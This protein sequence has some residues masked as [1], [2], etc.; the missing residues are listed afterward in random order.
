MGIWKFGKAFLLVLLLHEGRAVKAELLHLLQNAELGHAWGTTRKMPRGPHWD[1]MSSRPQPP[2]SN[3]SPQAPELGQQ[4]DLYFH[5]HPYSPQP[6]ILSF[7]D[8]LRPFS[9]TNILSFT[10]QY[11]RSVKILIN[12]HNLHFLFWVNSRHK[13]QHVFPRLV[14]P[15]LWFIIIKNLDLTV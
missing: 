6:Q 10:L 9:K 15:V 12:F 11:T 14:F 8:F 5:L 1:T 4:A 2:W 3:N 13:I 7:K